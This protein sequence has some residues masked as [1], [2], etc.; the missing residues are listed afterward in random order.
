L[1]G[2]SYILWDN[3][4]RGAQISCPHIEKS[5]T[6]AYYT[7]RK[8]GVSEIVATAAST[9]HLFTGNN[10]APKGDLASRSLQVRLDVDRADPENRD[11]KHPDP[12]EW[13]RNN[14]AELLQAMYVILMGN[15]TL[16]LPRNAAMKTRFKMWWRVVGSAVEHAA[17][18]HAESIDP[19]AYKEHDPPVSIDFKSM[20]LEQEEDEEEAASLGH[21]LSIMQKQWSALQKGFQASDVVDF[22]NDHSNVPDAVALRTFFLPA[23]PANTAAEPKSIGCKLRTHVGEV[24]PYGGRQLVLKRAPKS[25][26]SKKAVHYFVADSGE[27]D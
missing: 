21:A 5:C 13:T 6:A 7:D 25:P 20:F 26:N 11:F 17:K 8:L 12:V 16:K 10:I 1:Y 14:R 22:L 9:I 27:P 24:V 15:P 19:A 18:L 3:I 23:A 2:V 4:P